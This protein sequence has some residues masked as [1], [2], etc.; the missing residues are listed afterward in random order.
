MYTST[1][2]HTF[3]ADN[4]SSAG[5]GGIDSFTKLMLHADGADG[6]TTFTDSELTPKTVTA[7]GDAQIDTAQKVFGTGSALFDGTGDYLTTADH[8]DWTIG[9]GSYTF[10]ARVRFADLPADGD[11]RVLFSQA[12]DDSNFRVLY[13]NNLV[14]AYRILFNSTQFGAPMVFAT[15]LSINTWYHIAW[16]KSGNDYLVFKDGVQQGTTL[17]DTTDLEDLTGALEIGRVNVSGGILYFNGHM[18]EIRISKGVARWT[19]NFTPPSG[20]YTE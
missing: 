20:P 3:F 16:V 5:I 15:T 18:D 7:A 2:S 8:A 4:S 6:S 1:T 19:S 11:N 9:T 14:G 17:T 10:D 12:T 13:I